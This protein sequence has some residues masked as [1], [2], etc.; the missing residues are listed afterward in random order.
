MS[1]FWWLFMMVVVTCY[2]GNLIA[3]LTFSRIEFQVNDLKKLLEK[4]NMYQWGF[5]G[6]SVIKNFLNDSS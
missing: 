3:F 2:S 1:G 5:L 4:Q 6:D